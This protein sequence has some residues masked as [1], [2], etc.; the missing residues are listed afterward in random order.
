MKE[1]QQYVETAELHHDMLL[2][3]TSC[4]HQYMV[5]KKIVHIMNDGLLK[6]SPFYY[7]Y[8]TA[9]KVLNYY[10]KKFHGLE[11]AASQASLFSTDFILDVKEVAKF[12]SDTCEGK[13]CLFFERIYD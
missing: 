10:L 7:H 12:S 11:A 6:H 13:R 9:M 5:G 4:Y 3:A 2:I 1:L 8:P